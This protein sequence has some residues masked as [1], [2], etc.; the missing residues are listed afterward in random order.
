MQNNQNELVSIIVSAYNVEKYL[1][2]CLESI[3]K[4]TYDNLEILLIDD[5]S[6]DGTGAICDEFT[7]KDPR[8]RVIHQKNQGLWAV[9]NRG[10]AEAKGEYLAFI[11]GD[12]YFHK[13][14]IRM[15]Y[16]AINKDGHRYSMSICGYKRTSNDGEDITS[17]VS[18]TMTEMNRPQLI[19]QF[20]S[21][22]NCTTFTVNWNK[23]YR[24][25]SIDIPFQR[26]YPRCQD[27]DSNLYAYLT[28]IDSAIFIDSILYYWRIR[29]GQLTGAEDNCRLQNLCR[30][31]I[32]YD[33]YIK[34]S[35][36]VKSFDH[37]LLMALYRRMAK[38]LE[39]SIRSDNYYNTHAQ[40]KEIERKTAI[41]FILCKHEP[42]TYKIGIL[43]ALNFP[44][45]RRLLLSIKR[46]ISVP[47]ESFC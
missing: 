32:F 3:I 15:H 24:K 13:D 38:W 7:S 26:A 28:S 2:T 18:P 45:C 1:P 16:E 21:S 33:N 36:N 23:L 14:F 29:P 31:L 27:M 30:S 25:D 10:Q 42:M 37:Y 22:D 19:K 39:L 41:S 11:D 43:L 6:M 8:A 34:L 17:N 20:F 47:L 44:F 9:R 4:Q 12:D 46:S 35:D 40:I 5:G